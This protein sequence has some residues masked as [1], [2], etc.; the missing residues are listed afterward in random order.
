MCDLLGHAN[1]AQVLVGGEKALALVDTGSMITSIGE[2]FYKEQLQHKYPLQVLNSLLEVGAGRHQLDYFGY[3]E[4]EM[5]VPEHGSSVWAPGLVAPETSNLRV[6]L[7]IGTNVIKHLLPSKDEDVWTPA[8]N[9]VTVQQT[10]TP[11]DVAL[12]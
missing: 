3:A 9:A 1:E 11:E 4:L 10:A 8:I 6:P 12:L 7:I 2:S 5:L